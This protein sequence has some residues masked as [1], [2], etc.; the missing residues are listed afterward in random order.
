M[1][2]DYLRDD[3][4]S[5]CSSNG[6]KSFPRRQCCT[7]VRF[8]LELDL[9][10][11]GS[12]TTC[13]TKRH[14][15]LRRSRSKAV[16]ST[17]ISALHR[18]SQA[19]INAVKKQLPFHESV[20]SPSTSARNGALKGLLPRSL[21]RKLFSRKSF[22]RKADNKESDIGPCTL[23]HEIVNERDKPSDQVAHQSRASTSTSAS[24][25]GSWGESEFFTSE[26]LRSSSGNSVSSS[27]NDVVEGK[28]DLPEKKVHSKRVGQTV[29]EDS[30]LS[31]TSSTYSGANTK[32]WPNEEEK[33][34]LSPVSV[35]DCPFE[36][37]EE[38]SSPFE[39]KLARLEGTK[40]K[41]LH[42]LRRFEC[43]AQLEPVDLEKR[44]SLSEL[45]H[46]APQSPMQPCSMSDNKEGNQTEQKAQELLNLV[47]TTPHGTKSTAEKLLFDFF[48]ERVDQ[49]NEFELLKAAEDWVIGNSQ[50]LLQRW[51]VQDGRKVY[52]RDME[53]GGKWRILV[54]EKE[55]V[56]LDVEV[57]VWTSLLNELS[58]DLF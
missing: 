11:R 21:S 40:K 31:A 8:L 53:K 25:S 57:E 45:N 2:K 23:Y 34:Q 22:W 50:E 54:E 26:I 12:P 35:L 17:T 32:E 30:I 56:A 43:L 4:L 18:A 36:D 7:T 13:R 29:G 58:D 28:T 47:K 16:A 55:E 6:F 19:V 42:K 46:E 27:E 15:L 5:S 41:L 38:I 49:E 9:K 44:I 14:R 52:V 48:R 10:A 3:F 20:K 33:E 51:E 24:H 39:S 37:D 1:L